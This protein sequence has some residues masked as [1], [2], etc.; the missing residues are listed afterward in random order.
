LREG[1]KPMSRQYVHLSLDQETAVQVGQRKSSQP[2]MLIIQAQAAHDQG[3]V[4]YEGHGLVWLADFVPPEFIQ[5]E[6]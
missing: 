5:L 6:G 1:L 3:I 2:V 4:F